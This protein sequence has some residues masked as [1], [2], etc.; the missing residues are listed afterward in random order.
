MNLSE[1]TALIEAIRHNLSKVIV[2]KESGVNL[3]LTALL[4]N[5]HVLL[6]DVPGTGKTLLAKTLARSLDC[7]FKRIQFTPDLLPSDLSG[8]NYY[9]QRS[10]EFQFRPGPV[11]A[12][13]LLA[14]EINRATPRTQSSLLEC[15]EERQITIDGVTHEL[16]RPF[17]VI[18][19]QNPIDSQGTFP[20][21]EAQLD[22]FLMRITTGYPTFEEGVHILQRFRENN[23]LEDTA[24]VASGEQVVA[25]QRLA[26]GISVS[27]ELL[28][29]MISV[30]EATRKAPSVRLGAS[31]R[32]GFAL[33]RAAQGYALIQGRS[34][35]LPDDIKA[36]AVP[37]LAHRL[38]LQRGPGVREGQPAEV[39]LQVLRE[40]E[41]P[42]ETGVL[43]RGGRVE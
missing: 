39:V 11:F 30:V 2:G 14:D 5:G 38:I 41:V 35:C 34:Y 37:V 36:V 18:A 15:M 19:T 8:I 13:I 42:A 40:V 3:L 22:R 4:A 6:E 7:A 25:L 33:L 21:P 20:L 12:S 28:A 27:D 43:S 9:N 24:A 29:Y 31:P 1:A 26:A 10:G 32:A 16:Q 17:L 23:P